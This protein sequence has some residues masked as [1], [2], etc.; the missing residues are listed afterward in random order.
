[1]GEQLPLLGAAPA[2]KVLGVDLGSARVGVTL[3]H[4]GL[5]LEVVAADTI[6]VTDHD[7]LAPVVEEIIACVR[8]AEVGASTC[9]DIV[10]EHGSLYPGK[11]PWATMQI[12]K[13]H[14]IS[15]RL[16]AEIRLALPGPW[17]RIQAIPR[18]T[19]AH[20][21]VPHHHGGISTAASR[22]ALRW[23]V[24]AIP[25]RWAQR[26]ALRLL[27]LPLD[28]TAPQI[29]A[30]WH[31]PLALDLLESIL[32]AILSEPVLAPLCSAA[33]WALL[34]TQDEIDAL[35]AASWLVLPQESKASRAAGKRVRRRNGA[36]VEIRP[37]LTAEERRR[38]ENAK[39]RIGRAAYPPGASPE[40][41]T[42][43][44]RLGVMTAE[45]AW[46][47]GCRC[48]RVTRHR[49]AVAEG[50]APRWGGAGR[51]ELSCAL[52]R[53]MAPK[54]R[55]GLT[56]AVAK[57]LWQRALESRGAPAVAEKST[58]PEKKA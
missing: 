25:L 45:E 15:S 46:A 2:A 29:E 40:A 28:A 44:A 43:R 24:T 34:H 56:A 41:A 36:P 23:D 14:A 33:S 32:T 53:P 39:R 9:R 48:I 52:A 12:A 50:T 55:G 11:T 30:A 57:P 31:P 47:A 16:L 13:A 8:A 22:D 54:I 18:S 35:G 1:M 27:G 58:E 5:P 6:Q 21:V 10:C 37:V 38:K 42:Q 4:A 26:D 49:R 7:H 51:H 20:R 17:Y 3:V 19:W